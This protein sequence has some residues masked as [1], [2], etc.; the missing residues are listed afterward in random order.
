MSQQHDTFRVE[1]EEFD[2]L[3]KIKRM[4]AE[5]KEPKDT[6]RSEDAA[7]GSGHSTSSHRRKRK[8]WW[9]KL[10]KALLIIALILLAL[11]IVAAITVSILYYKGKSSMLNYGDASFVF[12][13]PTDVQTPEV[14]QE[15]PKDYILSYDDG[16][17][18]SY[19]GKTYVLNENVTTLLFIGV[20]KNSIEKEEYYGNGGEADCILLVGMDTVT[21]KTNIV[22]ISRDSC[23]QVDIYSANGKYLESRSTQL[24]RAFA[25]GDGQQQSCENVVKSVS[26]LLYGLP[27]RSYVVMD[28]DGIAVA[29][30]AIGGVTLVPQGDILKTEFSSYPVGEKVTLWGNKA[31]RYIKFRNSTDVASNLDRMARQ[32]QYITAF[33]AQ[34]LKET[35]SDITTLLDL[36]TALGDYIFTDLSLADTT[37]LLTCFVNNGAKFNFSTITGTLEMEAGNAIYHL[38]QSSLYET[39]LRVFYT[40][41]ED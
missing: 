33:V 26:R 41:L 11:L 10:L 23:A 37:F 24:C 5:P 25:Y 31:L 12:T 9:R 7:P 29:N 4:I 28:M 18:V 30:D 16:K 36:Y 32:K 14:S 17:T 20:D 8:P 15:T 13:A 34:A 27:I 2:E 22:N 21:G 38:D 6:E 19:Q 1:I 35:K 40:P 39:V 3:A